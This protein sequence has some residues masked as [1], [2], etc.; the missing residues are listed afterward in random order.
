MPTKTDSDPFA[1]VREAGTGAPNFELDNEAIV[2]R[3]AQWQSLCKF[4][5]TGA[6]HDTI[7]I[8]FQSLPQDMDAFVR[9]LYDFCPDL[10]D[11]GTG[12]VHEMVEVMEETGEELDPKLAK[13]IEGVDF[14]DENYGLEIL[15]R[16]IERDEVIQLWWD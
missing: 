15:K 14:S 2:E 11:Q 12:C 8:E 13:L 5:V 16:E 1:I 3:L 4:K 10:V 6:K 9:D 7:D